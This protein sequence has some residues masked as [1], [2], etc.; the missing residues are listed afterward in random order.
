[1]NKKQKKQ[2]DDV[3]SEYDHPSVTNDVIHSGLEAYP[4]HL[5]KE[6]EDGDAL[7]DFEENVVQ[8]SMDAK[9]WNSVKGKS[10]DHKK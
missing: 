10:E 6:E 2:L 7:S 4:G 9:T 1:M 5:E 8:H 3:K